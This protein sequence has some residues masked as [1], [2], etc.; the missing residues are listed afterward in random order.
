MSGLADLPHCYFQFL[1]NFLPKL[2]VNLKNKTAVFVQPYKSEITEFH[3]TYKYSNKPEKKF[4]GVT[5][6]EYSLGGS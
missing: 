6:I 5:E 4:T 1:G 2:P 3:C